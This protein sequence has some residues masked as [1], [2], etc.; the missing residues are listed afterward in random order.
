[1]LMQNDPSHDFDLFF[2]RSSE[3]GRE[4]PTAMPMDVYRRGDDIWVHMDL[5]GVAADSVDISVERN[6]LTVGAQRSWQREDGDE[7]YLAERPRGSHRRRVHLGDGLDVD[8]IEAD[9]IDGVLNLRIPVAE[10]ARPRRINVGTS[11]P[12]ID[13]ASREALA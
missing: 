2:S 7:F 1:M 8:E 12:A 5:P 6:V 4:G 9:L 3:R 10:R 11:A 13:V